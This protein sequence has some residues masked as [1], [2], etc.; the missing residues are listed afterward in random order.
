[1][2][3][4]LSYQVLKPCSLLQIKSRIQRENIKFKP[5]IFDVAKVVESSSEEEGFKAANILDIGP[6]VLL[7][8]ILDNVPQ[9]ISTTFN[10]CIRYC[11]PIIF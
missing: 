11:R 10:I 4:R 2:P 1:M 7:K 3:G 6:Q 9:I 8:P 5:L